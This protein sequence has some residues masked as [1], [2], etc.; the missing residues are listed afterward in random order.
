MSGSARMNTK[1][2]TERH[3]LGSAPEM[4]GRLP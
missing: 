2:P 3:M 1:V 4:T